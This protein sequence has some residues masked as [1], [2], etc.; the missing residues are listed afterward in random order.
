MSYKYLCIIIAFW[1]SSCKQFEIVRITKLETTSLNLI[2]NQI[3]ASGKIIDIAERGISDYGFCY[4]ENTIPTIQ[5]NRISLNSTNKTGEFSAKIVGLNAFKTYKVR[6]YAIDNSNIIYGQTLQLIVYPT[7]LN[8]TIDSV[9]IISSKLINIKGSVN[10]VGG[11]NILDYGLCWS[12]NADPN[13]TIL[14]NKINYG[15]LANDTIFY[16][17]I[18]N[19]ILDTTYHIRAFIQVDATLFYYSTTQTARVNSLKITTGIPLIYDSNN[20]SLNGYFNQLGADSIQEYGFCWSTTNTLPTLN[21]NKKNITSPP[22]YNIFTAQIPLVISNTY[23]IRTYAIVNGTVIYGNV[24][25][26]AF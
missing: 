17:V 10:G 13:P 14:D 19:P 12:L 18:N 20:I 6:A 25:F 26:K 8:E 3:I 1:L 9:T 7:N 23:Y 22:G 2:N 11:I 21:D 4:S 24:Q 5:D 15:K 16:G